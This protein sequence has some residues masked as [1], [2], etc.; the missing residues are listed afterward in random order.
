MEIHNLMED[1]VVGIVEETCNEEERK[2]GAAGCMSPE[3]RFD[4]AC[5]VLNR[6][7]QQYVSSGRG[8]AHAEKALNDNPQ[9]LVDILTLV[10]DGLRRVSSVQRPYYGLGSG[11]SAPPQGPVF[12]FPTIKGRVLDCTTFAPL[13]NS[14]VHLLCGGEPAA[15]VD[16]RWQNPFILDPKIEGTFLFLP[17]PVEAARPGE[18]RLFEFEISVRDPLYEPLQHFFKIALTAEAGHDSGRK[19]PDFRLTDM[20]AAPK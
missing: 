4:I 19:N 5:Y 7:P 17:R 6:I 16:G 2:S 1:L 11:E 10:H 13:A 15:M 12:V 20:Y 3:S 9:L 8:A 18:Q 14:A